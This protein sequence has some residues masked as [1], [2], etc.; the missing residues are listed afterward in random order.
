MI[1]TID[2]PLSPDEGYG[3]LLS[4]V[5]TNRIFPDGMDF[6]R[7][8]PTS[9][10][11]AINTEFLRLGE[12]DPQ[13][14]GNFVLQHFAP[15]QPL[16]SRYVKQPRTID[17]HVRYMLSDV[18]V[19]NN[20]EAK[21]PIIP[22]EHDFVAADDTRFNDVMF[23]WD[24]NPVVEGVLSL[25]SWSASPT[26]EDLQA[27]NYYKLAEG[28]VI[29]QANL[30]DRFG[31]IPNGTLTC[32]LSRSQPPLFADTVRM[33]GNYYPFTGEP[34]IDRQ[35]PLIRFLPQMVR[36]MA[37][38]ERGKQYLE[39]HPNEVAYE[40]V[41]R[42]PDGYM[43]RNKDMKDTPRPESYRQDVATIN[44]ALRFN[45][46]TT[47]EK[48]AGHM[49][50]GAE[51]GWDFS[52]DRQCKDPERLSSI[53][54]TDLIPTDLN[55]MIVGYKNT[56]ADAY[57][58]KMQIPDY[59][60][61]EIAEARQQALR[62]RQEARD[63]AAMIN[64]YTWNPDT[65]LYHDYDF[66]RHYKDETPIHANQT[67][68]QS[69]ATV[70]PLYAGIASDKQVN[71]VARRIKSDFMRVG[72][73]ATTLLNTGQQ[74]DGDM[75][76]P[77][78]NRKAQRAFERSGHDD[79]GRLIRG[80]FVAATSSIYNQTGRVYE[81]MNARD[82][83]KG[84]A[85]EYDVTGDFGM[86]LAVVASMRREVYAERDELLSGAHVSRRKFRLAMVAA[87][88]AYDSLHV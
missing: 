47:A 39:Q 33:L 11:D 82:M 60:A 29:N 57:E 25:E 76:W 56:I 49:R 59:S 77:I 14:L 55:A 6:V 3:S 88:L 71:G 37:W 79:L 72:G 46:D 26:I 73:L 40:H 9:P 44:E 85:G 78:L 69:L 4:A 54:T 12:A 50:A 22:V 63:L 21:D 35:H 58:L 16:T 8:R 48:V 17:E 5:Q 61:D 30:I 36:E 7:M 27:S 81:K 20:S 32:M 15:L 34:A 2:D 38:W 70:F 43:M 87:A 41:V 68:A 75:S 64:K 84:T 42:M 53:R 62:Y 52:A 51:W 24:T 67:A 86:S 23:N 66:A 10:I 19:C 65:D 13:L 83:S 31:H 1:E 74:W 28:M 18:L 45:P 80:R